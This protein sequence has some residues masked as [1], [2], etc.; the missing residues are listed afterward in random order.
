[1]KNADAMDRR[2]LLARLAQWSG[3]AL[4]V[5]GLGGVATGCAGKGST[6]VEPVAPNGLGKTAARNS[7]YFDYANYA[8][9]INGPGSSYADY[10]N[11]SN[12]SNYY[13]YSDAYSD[14]YAEAYSDAY[15]DTYSESY[16]DSYS[17]SGSYSNYSEYSDYQEYNDY[18]DDY[19]DN[20]ADAYADAS[21]AERRP[22]GGYADY[23]D[24]YA[25]SGARPHRQSGAGVGRATG[26]HSPFRGA[27]RHFLKGQAEAVHGPTWVDEPETRIPAVPVPGTVAPG[28]AHQGAPGELQRPERQKEG[29]VARS[30]AGPSNRPG[31]PRGGHR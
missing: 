3:A 14:A 30:I 15:S 5:A 10:A 25:D 28:V 16:N 22:V 6:S 7:N 24:G 11:Y 2:T 31:G 19:F 9:Y 12:Y 26:V 4:A 13:D 1:M 29:P 17:D 23:A 21:S 8:N 27:G 18:S 20:Y